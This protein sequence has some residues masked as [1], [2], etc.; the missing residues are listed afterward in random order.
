MGG[1]VLHLPLKIF[2]SK[3][4]Y[5]NLYILSKSR[6]NDIPDWTHEPT[7]PHH[8]QTHTFTH[9]YTHSRTQDGHIEADTTL[10]WPRAAQHQWSTSPITDRQAWLMPTLFTQLRCAKQK[11]NGDDLWALSLQRSKALTFRCVP[12]PVG[13]AYSL[14]QQWRTRKSPDCERS[15]YRDS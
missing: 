4:S 15:W 8:T 14:A 2:L 9:I 11:Y 12:A 5:L 3:K 1:I 13:P 6:R 7:H 10:E